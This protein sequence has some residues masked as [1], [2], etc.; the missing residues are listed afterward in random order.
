MFA[1]APDTIPVGDR[2]GSDE[3]RERSVK[4]APR[5]DAAHVFSSVPQPARGIVV[6]DEPDESLSA[7]SRATWCPAAMRGFPPQPQAGQAIPGKWHGWYVYLIARVQGELLSRLICCVLALWGYACDSDR[8]QKDKLAPEAS[9]PT[10][11]GPT[12]GQLP[13]MPSSTPD[14]VDVALTSEILNAFTHGLFGRDSDCIATASET[15]PMG[16]GDARLN[17]RSNLNYAGLKTLVLAACHQS[18]RTIGQIKSDQEVCNEDRRRYTLRGHDIHVGPAAIP[19]R[20]PK[21]V[22]RGCAGGA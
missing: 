3:S 17:Q 19:S 7:L 15:I 10:P 11:C 9:I 6:R 4:L 1:A 12:A 18:T 16:L 13:R 22:G 8:S 21:D 14:P 20:D 2:Q 5:Q